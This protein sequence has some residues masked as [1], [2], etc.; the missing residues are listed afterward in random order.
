MF[1]SAQSK[2]AFVI[3]AVVWG[4]LAAP[5]LV[6]ADTNSDAPDP[7]AV[8]AAP[9]IMSSPIS[10]WSRAFVS[11]SPP[12]VTPTPIADLDIAPAT[13]GNVT[14][15]PATPAS[16]GNSFVDPPPPSEFDL[17]VRSASVV[18][19][20][21]LCLPA[22]RVWGRGIRR[23]QATHRQWRVASRPPSPASLV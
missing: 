10:T 8:Y 22:I 18:C 2:P 15:L 1:I 3:A 16:S 13:I 23:R 7:V 21:A 11:A 17:V 9:L 4:V 19:G 20:L 5:G 12:I 6:H 14:V